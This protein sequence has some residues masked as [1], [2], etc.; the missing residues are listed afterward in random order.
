MKIKTAAPLAV[1]AMALLG[2]WRAPRIAPQESFLPPNDLRIGVN[3]IEAKGISR[4]QY[5]KVMDLAQAIYGPIV[6]AKGGNFVINRL[7]EDDT[8]N[9][10]AQRMGSD[11]VINMYGGLAR[12]ETITQDG[13]MLVVCHELGHHLGG[14]PKYGGWNTWASNEGQSD[15][16]ANMKCLRKVF[17]DSRSA[18]F[19]K[20][21]AQDDS[22]A[23]AGCAK[24]WPGNAAER[25]LCV[26]GAMAGMSVTSLF[27]VLRRQE[28]LPRFSTPDSA[29]VEE[30][31]D[32]HPD[33]QC[34][35]DTYYN[36][37]LCAQSDAR[38]VSDTD[39]VVATCTRS[40]GYTTGI[41]PRCWYK[42]GDAETRAPGSRASA[43]VSSIGAGSVWRGL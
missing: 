13:M 33:T 9:A 20:K 37:S 41:R 2:L 11:Y 7:W 28:A 19:T 12:H 25:A 32:S 31:S 29:E 5:E 14:A 8:V 26:R 16:F 10:S 18:Q 30:T 43:L 1:A 21:D 34:R 17:R 23:A 4:E 15:Y 6:A 42:P 36:G 40:Q 22:E 38:D 35:L 39:P 24:A 3:S 27:R